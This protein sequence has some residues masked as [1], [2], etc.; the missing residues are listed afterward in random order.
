MLEDNTT[1]RFERIENKIKELSETYSLTEKE[2]RIC[3]HLVFGCNAKQIAEKECVTYETV[4]WY[5]KIIYQKIGVNKQTE[6]MSLFL[7]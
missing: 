6:L 3:R 1:D 7:V 5:R 4:R 2:N